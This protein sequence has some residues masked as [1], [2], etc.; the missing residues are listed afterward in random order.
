MCYGHHKNDVRTPQGNN[1]YLK[2]SKRK[3]QFWTFLTWWLYSS[4]P[5]HLRQKHWKH[6][7]VGSS[8]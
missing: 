5:L 3:C 8:T 6:P 2:N 4:F 7:F 1:M